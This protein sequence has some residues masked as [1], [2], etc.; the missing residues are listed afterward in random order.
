MNLGAVDDVHREIESLW[1][2]VS[3]LQISL[4]KATEECATIANKAKQKQTESEAVIAVNEELKKQVESLQSNMVASKLSRL[5][6]ELFLKEA[7]S[8]HE[9]GIIIRKS[10]YNLVGS[11]QGMY[12]NLML[13]EKVLNQ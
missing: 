4:Q 5:D 11:I 12:Q 1:T 7:S 9:K 8:A 10:F 6:T 13:N 2:Q 3:R